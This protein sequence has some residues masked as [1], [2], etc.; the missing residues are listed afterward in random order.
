MNA[1]SKTFTR[2]L[3]AIALMLVLLP[4]RGAYA[5]QPDYV[6]GPKDVLNITVWD[7]PN[8][9]GKFTV[10]A[11]GT[12]TFPLIG[13]VKAAGL[14]LRDL[15]S[16]L[17]RQL[18]DGFVRDP[19]LS[20]TVEQYQS[21]MVQVL[22]EVKL[23]GSYA[24]TGQ[25]SLIEVLARA[26]STTDLAGGTAIITR[27]GGQR[28]VVA[29]SGTDRPPADQ[30]VVRVNLKNLQSGALSE[31]L[32]LHDGDVVFIPRAEKIF[33]Y[34]Q[35]KLPGS[36]AIQDQTTVMQAIAL[37]GGLTERGSSGRLQ[38]IR[39]VNGVKK[40]LKAKLF[41]LVQPGDTIVVGERLF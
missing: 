5:Q 30:D 17:K 13:R 11:D 28:A 25:M 32:Q 20:V 3:A 6:V 23:P 22:G 19:Q 36:Y 33:V 35:V 15:E 1:N 26:G 18:A 14:R 39:Q 21:Q 7:Q 12:F 34:G 8:L 24:L 9:S 29:T 27:R 40:Q 41:D 2:I 10:E 37:A 16:G 38:I 31:N 4:L